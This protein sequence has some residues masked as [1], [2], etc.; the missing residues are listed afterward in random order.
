M[1][2]LR[3]CN[4]LVAALS[5]GVGSAIAVTSYG[6]GIGMTEYGPGAG[7]WPFILGV[8]LVVVA[9]LLFLD[10]LKH[11]SEYLAQE[12]L[13][14]TAQNLSAYQM[15]GIVLIYAV[16]IFILGF[17]LATALFLAVAMYRLGAENKL[18]IVTVSGLFLAFVY[19]L[20]GLLLH[21][22]L[23]LPFFME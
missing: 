9:G 7:F 5:A 12:I 1:A 13:L 22:S 4:Y 11:N 6:Y 16:L 2:N 3:N 19:V 17:Y 21:I 8:A 10:T 20:F 14:S 15:M 18:Q 23:P